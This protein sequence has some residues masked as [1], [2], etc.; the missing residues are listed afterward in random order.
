MHFSASCT[1]TVRLCA[2]CMCICIEQLICRCTDELTRIISINMFIIRKFIIKPYCKAV[3]C[4]SIL[5]ANGWNGATSWV[6]SGPE[7]QL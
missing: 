4:C 1:V 7:D 5:P 2:G 3:L 6:V